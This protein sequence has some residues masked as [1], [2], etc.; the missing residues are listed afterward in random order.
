LAE[1]YLTAASQASPDELP[2]VAR[3]LVGMVTRRRQRKLLPRIMAAVEQLWHQRHGTLP[4]RVTTARP[5][6]R[7]ALTAAVGPGVA[8]TTNVDPTLIG[9]AVVERGDN[10]FD[11]SIRT[12][13]RRL[14]QQLVSNPSERL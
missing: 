8:V 12:H 2:D 4:V 3:A 6:D 10:R 5:V 14:R 11:G 9:G 7:A 13:L 1:A